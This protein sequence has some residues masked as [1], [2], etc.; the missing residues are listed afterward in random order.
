MENKEIYELILIAVKNPD[1]EYYKK[2][3]AWEILSQAKDYDWYYECSKTDCVT[4]FI[5]SC[6]EQK[7]SVKEVK[8]Y[9]KKEGMAKIKTYCFYD[10]FLQ[11]ARNIVKEYKYGEGWWLKR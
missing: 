4:K 10:C 1:K 6:I 11:K 8:K 2:F 3:D 9:L 5:T 7:A